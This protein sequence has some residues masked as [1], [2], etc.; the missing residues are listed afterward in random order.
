MMIAPLPDL[1]SSDASAFDRY[2]ELDGLA[3]IDDATSELAAA[4]QTAPPGNR[5]VIGAILSQRYTQQGEVGRGIALAEGVRDQAR[6]GA[7]GLPLLLW[8]ALYPQA[9]WEPITATASH[10]GIEPYLVAG[11]IREESRFD[12]H[13]VSAADAYGLMQLIPGTARSAARAAGLPSPDPRALT[14]PQTNITLGSLVLQQLLRQFNRLDLVLA[15]YNAGPGSVARWQA[16]SANLD[17]E[18]FIEE[19]PYAETRGYVKTVMQSTAMYRWLY[20]DG[21]PSPL[22]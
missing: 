18:A 2:R 1:A 8:E 10:L 21:H 22:P 17:P 5:E 12:P 9:F 14:D 16:R 13:A 11:V 19:I 15:A 7:Q 6:G 20:R 4:A 3:Q